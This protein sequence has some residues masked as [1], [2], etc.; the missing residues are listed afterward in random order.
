MDT[1]KPNTNKT[2]GELKHGNNKIHTSTQQKPI[3]KRPKRST[4]TK[5]NRNNKILQKQTTIIRAQKGLNK[6]RVLRGQA[7]SLS[8]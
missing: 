7:S 4:K 3:P 1:N 6:S 5:T 8:A 2:K